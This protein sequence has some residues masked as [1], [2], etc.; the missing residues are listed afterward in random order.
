MIA[1]SNILVAAFAI[2][3]YF[4]N[5]ENGAP[6]L[7]ATFFVLFQAVVMWFAP[8]LPIFASFL[9]GYARLPIELTMA[10]GVMLGGLAGYLGWVKGG[11][12]VSPT[13]MSPGL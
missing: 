8:D 4:R 9:S 2:T 13:K 7:V 11:R 1:I 12:R 3:L 5:R 6:W 10:V